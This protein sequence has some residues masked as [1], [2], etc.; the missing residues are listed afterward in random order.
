MSRRSCVS[1]VA[2]IGCWSRKMRSC[3]GRRPICRSPICREKALPARKRARRRR[4]PR[5]G[6][7]PGTQAR[8]PALLPL[9]GQPCHRRRTAS[10][11][12]GPTH[13]STP[14]AMIRSSATA[15]WSRR[16]AMPVNRWPSAPPGGSAR[17]PV[18]ECVRQ[19][20]RQERQDRATGARRSR[21]A[22]F[23]CRC[24]KSIVAGRHY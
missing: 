18:V 16:P 22:R 12:T 4:D 10:R 1:C 13:C 23:H 17:Q 3:A 8:P 7:V 9:A 14:T 15:T 21:R 20:A 5:G 11:P 24:A 6:D 2:G 19:E